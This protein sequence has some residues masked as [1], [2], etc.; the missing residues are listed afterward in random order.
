MKADANRAVSG[1]NY[2]DKFHGSS[3]YIVDRF[4]I[5]GAFTKDGFKFMGDAIQHHEKYVGGEPWV[6]GNFS[7]H[8]P[9]AATLS[10]QLKSAY[11]AEYIETWRNYLNKAQFISYQSFKDAGDKLGALDSDTSPLLELFSLIS[12]HTAVDWPEIASAFQAHQRVVRPSNPDKRL[13]GDSNRTYIQSLQSLEGVVKGLAIDPTKTNDPTAA[14]S[15]T[16]A[17]M[18]AHV[19]TGKIEGDFNPDREGGMDKTNFKL[20]EDPIISAENLAAQAPLRAASGGAAE[21]CTLI[22]PLLKK[23]PFN[24]DEPN[25]ATADEVAKIFAPGTGSFAQHYNISLKTLVVLRGSQLYPAEGSKPPVSQNFLRFLNSAQKICSTLFR[26]G[27]NQP[28]LD[29]TLT[30]VKSQVI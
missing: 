19:E 21:F 8:L 1:F 15:V 9:D 25:E 24:P 29:F 6:L 30:E 20:L 11:S 14:Q 5:P 27:G 16:Q 4:P 12:Y 2:N 17:A 13:I 10:A 3:L 23:F 22:G 7:T 18:I 28:E 26:V